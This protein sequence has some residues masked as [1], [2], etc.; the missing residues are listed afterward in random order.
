MMQN[1]SWKTAAI[2][3]L[4][5]LVLLMGAAWIN[6]NSARISANDERISKVEALS[7]NINSDR[8]KRTIILQ[9]IDDRL[10]KIER[11][12]DRMESRG[13]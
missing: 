4:G 6:S 13:R 11:R 9:S 2:S 10:G 5:A 1:G 7:L 12:L 8:D 3:A